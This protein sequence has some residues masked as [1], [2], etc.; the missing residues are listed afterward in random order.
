MSDSALSECECD[1]ARSP[2]MKKRRKYE[3]S[4]N[5]FT[6]YQPSWEKQYGFVSRST[7]SSAHF[8]CKVCRKDVS[9][10]HQGVLDIKRHSEGKMHKKNAT[11][12]R[13]QSQLNFKSLNDP[14]Q[15]KITAAEVRNTVMIAHHNAALC[16]SDHIG[17]MQ[18]KNFPDS[19]IASGYH[20][21]RT[22][23]ACILNYALAPYLK[24]ELVVAMK[25]EPY[26]LSVDASNDAGVR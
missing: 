11:S 12:M 14:I 26:S 17:P 7:T 9:I 20:C 25:T 15:D 6:S 22:K 8:Y 10:S 13:S 16:M 19:Q 18:R 21:A 23:T 1:E 2:K 3:G 4:A 24:N 5:Y